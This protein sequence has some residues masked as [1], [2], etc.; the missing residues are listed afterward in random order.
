MTLTMMDRI[1]ARVLGSKHFVVAVAVCT[2]GNATQ[3][4]G[5]VTTRNVL[6]AATVG[7]AA[8]VG[9]KK[10]QGETNAQGAATTANGGVAAG[11]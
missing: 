4:D 8:L 3:E 7:G 5:V 10:M 1:K 6:V 9:A 11:K 2:A